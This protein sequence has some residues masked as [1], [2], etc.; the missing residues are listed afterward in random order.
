MLPVSNQVPYR[1]QI[2]RLP[3]SFSTTPIQKFRY[4]SAGLL[5]FSQILVLLCKIS[6]SNGVL[7][8]LANVKLLLFRYYRLFVQYVK[9]NRILNCHIKFLVA[10]KY[11]YKWDIRRSLSCVVPNLS[12]INLYPTACEPF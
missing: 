7:F 2:L 12:N 8:L 9:H 1:F 10:T 5:S 11:E 3:Q 4:L 6:R